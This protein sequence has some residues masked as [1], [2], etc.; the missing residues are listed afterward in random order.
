MQP[1]SYLLVMATN[2]VLVQHGK[3]KNFL[4]TD[5]FFR[6]TLVR[7]SSSDEY[8]M[9]PLFRAVLKFRSTNKLFKYSFLALLLKPRPNALIFSLDLELNI[10]T[11][12][13]FDE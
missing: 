1:N 9:M 11:D 2:I 5:S 6:P 13:L 3:R 10:S 4:H 7:V 8:E 12:V